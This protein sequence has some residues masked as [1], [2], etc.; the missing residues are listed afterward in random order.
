MRLRPRRITAGP[1]A[2]LAL[3][4]GAAGVVF[5]SC[6]PF[7]TAD[8]VFDSHPAVLKQVAAAEPTVALTLDDGP[9]GATT[10][11]L[12]LHV[13]PKRG[14]RALRILEDFLPWAG[15][16]GLAVVTLGELVASSPGTRNADP[17]SGVVAQDA[18]R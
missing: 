12:V 7:R 15:G 4:V 10:P 17:R 9:D 3:V 5:V 6:R 13:D 14:E 2:Y 11:A 16:R 18:R 8:L 1:R